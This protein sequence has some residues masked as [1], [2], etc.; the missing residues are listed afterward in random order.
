MLSPYIMMGQISRPS[1]KD[2]F[3]ARGT[4]RQGASVAEYPGITQL[5]YRMLMR[6]HIVLTAELT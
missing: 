5:L 4:T 6:A 1:A 2:F 3:G